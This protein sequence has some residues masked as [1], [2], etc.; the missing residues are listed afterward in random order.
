MH[1]A[2]LTSKGQVTIPMFIRS[3]LG[4]KSGDEIGFVLDQDKIEVI[5][6][7]NVSD[8]YGSIK[9]KGVQNFK[10]IRKTVKKKVTG[11]IIDE[12]R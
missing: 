3:I 2:R 9:V 7:G 5:K 4:I 10:H 12:D 1:T 11:E 6:M 8:F